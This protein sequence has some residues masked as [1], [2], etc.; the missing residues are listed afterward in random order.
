MIRRLIHSIPIL[1]V[2]A[3]PSVA[4]T[5]VLRADPW[6]PY[7]CEPESER[8]GYM[9]ELATE[10]LALFGHTVVYETVSW[11]RGLQQAAEGE[12]DGVIGAVPEEVPGFVLGPALGTY[13]EVLVFRAGEGRPVVQ[14]SDLEGLRIGAINGYEHSDNVMTHIEDNRDDRTVVQ[15]ASGDDALTTN[16]RKL[17]AGR[18]DVVAE[19][20]A[21]VEY[22]AAEMGI[23]QDLDLIADSDSGDIFIAFSPARDGSGTYAGQLHEGMERL[24]ASGRYAEILSQYGIK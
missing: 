9:V 6:C 1:L 3:T 18:I 10:A 7:N 13:S 5:I 24:R 17:L 8:P 22:M 12:I 19:S 11:A 4:D 15:F 16:L 20:M 2:A 23:R 21:V 14:P